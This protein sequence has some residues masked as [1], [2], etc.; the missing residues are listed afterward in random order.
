MNEVPL[1][2]VVDDDEPFRTALGRLLNAGGYDVVLYA[3]AEAF[4]V[5]PHH[6]PPG[7]ILLDVQMD[8]IDGLQL[9]ERLAEREAALPI[10]FLTGAG[11]I[12][13]TVQALKRGAE[14]FL[15][16][17]VPSDVLF[18]AVTAALA[19][20]REEHNTREQLRSMRAVLDRLTRRERE[21]FNLVVRGKLNKQIAYQLGTA[22]RTVKA[23]RQSIVTKLEL[24]SAAQLASFAERLGIVDGGMPERR[25]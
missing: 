22:E 25:P 7:C 5:S 24:R 15:C 19:R 20:S 2:H 9:Q 13:S 3:S 1:V 21:V 16:K 17:P 12:P 18:A 23:H 14:D 8:G 6:P 10:L 4:L 11:D